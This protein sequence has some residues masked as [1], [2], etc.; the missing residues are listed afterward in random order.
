MI[1]EREDRNLFD[2][3]PPLR[4]IASG[5]RLRDLLYF[6]QASVRERG[7]IILFL[8]R[9]VSIL[10]TDFP[11][12]A[13]AV[14]IHG[15]KLIRRRRRSRRHC[16]L[17]ALTGCIPSSYPLQSSCITRVQI[18]ANWTYFRVRVTRL[19]RNSLRPILRLHKT[20]R[21]RRRVSALSSV[22]FRAPLK[23]HARMAKRTGVDKERGEIKI[24]Y[25]SIIDEG[26]E[27]AFLPFLSQK[28]FRRRLSRTGRTLI[29]YIYIT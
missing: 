27:S 12:H 6:P 5:F 19:F 1:T 16:L 7:S 15:W 22:P 26:H 2:S 23:T 20:R 24:S 17:G 29:R 8:E 9:S 14:I 10:Y 21:I 11:G 3:L 13:S 25:G 4:V 28:S 18:R